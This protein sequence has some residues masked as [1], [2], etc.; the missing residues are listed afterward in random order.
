YGP[1][2]KDKL[3]FPLVAIYPKE[4][5][6][7]SD[8]PVG[9]VNRDWV[10]EEH[11][12]AAKV[13]VDFLMKQEQQEKALKYGFRPGL[14]SIPLA[15]PIDAEHGVDPKEPKVVLDVPSVEVMQ[16]SRKAW[17]QNK[18]HSRV[19]IVF[20][21]SGSMNAGGKLNNAKR[22]AREVVAML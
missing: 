10:T 15:A 8:H 11:K 9:V 16:A 22:G 21:K 4:G 1:E 12:A 13:Y 6:F 14:E 18:K 2:Y 19:I 5:T 20:D 3:P 17:L 7:W